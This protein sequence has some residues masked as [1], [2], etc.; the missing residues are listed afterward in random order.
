[1]SLALPTFVE[2]KPEMLEFSTFLDPNFLLR[3]H[4]CLDI[5]VLPSC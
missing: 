4:D 3:I 5:S 1:M 2:Y